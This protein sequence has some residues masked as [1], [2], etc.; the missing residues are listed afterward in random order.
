MAMSMLE[1]GGVEIVTDGVRVADAHN[2]RGY[3]E[4]E[5]VKTLEVDTDA[6][7]LESARGKALKVISFLLPHLPPTYDYRVVFMHRDMGEI[8]TSQHKMLSRD[9]P[10]DPEVDRRFAHAYEDHLTVVDEMLRRRPCFEVLDLRFEEVLNGPSEQAERLAR[11]VGGALDV[12]RM[13]AV[14][15]RGLYRNRR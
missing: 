6:S 7:W 14:V 15:D 13:A 10:L 1:A 8:L 9:V 2:P 5:R 3:Y 11:F 12:T 4:Y